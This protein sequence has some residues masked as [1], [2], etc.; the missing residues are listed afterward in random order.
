M[1]LSFHILTS[2]TDN[3]QTRGPKLN[4]FLSIIRGCQDIIGTFVLG[5]VFER[6]PKLKVVC[7]EADAGWVPHY[8]YR[9][10]HAYDRHRYWLPAGTLTKNPSE[11]FRE[12]VYTTFQDDYVAF[13]VRN[14]CNIKRLMWAS[15]FPHS[16]STW[17]WSQDVI[18]KHTVGMT[19]DE[20]NLVL[21]DNV[22]EL[23]HLSI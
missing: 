4:S 7:V 13:Q 17:P 19:A 14:L 20:K 15:D 18:A 22:A 6:H 16:D 1:P 9:M 3:F 11:Y 8:M 2:S 5:G 10:D 12:N 21:H 23:Y